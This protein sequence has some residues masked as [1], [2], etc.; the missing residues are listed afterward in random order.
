MKFFRDD[1][2]IYT[3]CSTLNTGTKLGKT[4][5]ACAGF[6]ATY[7][8][9]ILHEENAI[10]LRTYVAANSA[11]GETKA[12]ELASTYVGWLKYK[13]YY[14]LP[15]VN[16]FSDYLSGI[17]CI[18]GHIDNYIR[19]LNNIRF[20]EE[21][22][23]LFIND[24]GLLYRDKKR[25]S[26]I[27]RTIANAVL[28]IY[29]HRVRFMYFPAHINI[30]N[31][32]PAIHKASMK[33]KANNNMNYDYL[34]NISNSVMYKIAY[35]GLTYNDAIDHITRNYLV[36]NKASIINFIDKNVSKADVLRFQERGT[37]ITI[38]NYNERHS[39]FSPY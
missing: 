27:C 13:Y 7:K 12:L 14:N 25:I 20:E 35:S 31:R 1:I 23:N 2:N 3:D 22:I 34:Q 30:D 4:D 16:I 15:N 32:D 37:E 36:Q 28:G 38:P 26:D 10:A 24:A 29:R 11:I 21:A 18:N 8:G 39:N 6:I 17:Q 5:L 9:E 19:E 33:F